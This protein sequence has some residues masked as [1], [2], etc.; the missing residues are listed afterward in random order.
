MATLATAQAAQAVNRQ[1][2]YGAGQATVRALA[3]VSV[4]FERARFTAVMGPSGSGKSTLMHCMAGLDRPTSG[5]AYVGGQDTS[6][7][8]SPLPPVRPCAKCAFGLPLAGPNA[9]LARS[10]V[11]GSWPARD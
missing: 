8:G 9:H 10:S 4:T 3:D 1:K 6:P 7:L 5:Q 2:T 11:R